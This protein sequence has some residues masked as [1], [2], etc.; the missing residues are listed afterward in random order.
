MADNEGYATAFARRDKVFV[1]T[2]AALV[3]GHTSDWENFGALHELGDEDRVL[4][5][6]VRKALLKYNQTPVAMRDYA[7]GGHNLALARQM[8]LRSAS[9]LYTFSRYC[10]LGYALSQVTFTPWRRRFRG[11][12]PFSEAYRSGHEEI[13]LPFDCTDEKLGAALRECIARCL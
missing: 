13:V 1:Y 7:P 2:M 11:F 9:T 10:S 3:N 12:E 6:S 8:G 4:G 5:A